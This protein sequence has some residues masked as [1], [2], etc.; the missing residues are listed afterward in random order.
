MNLE[1][2][3]IQNPVIASIRNDKD[4]N[5]VMISNS[6]IVFVLYGNIMSI[7]I[8]CRKLM[9]AGKIVFIHMDMIEGLKGDFCGIEYLKSTVNLTGILTTKASNVKHARKLDLY[10]IQRIFV[11]DSLSLTTGIKNIQE[12]GPS[13]IEV[14][15]GIASKI[16]K[17]LKLEVKVPIIASGLI[18]EKRDVQEAISAGAVAVSTTSNSLWNW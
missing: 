1:E 6:K 13:A 9:K 11:I 18:K 5:E 4:M 10:A 17:T 14:M 8:I 16:I 2:L 7:P 12:C 3:L 15:P